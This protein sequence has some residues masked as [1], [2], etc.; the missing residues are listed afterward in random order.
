MH[1]VVQTLP[2]LRRLLLHGLAIASLGGTLATAQKPALV[3]NIDEPGRVP[4]EAEVEFIASGCTSGNC[5]NFNSLAASVALLD[6]NTPVPAGKRLILRHISGTL[7]DNAACGFCSVALQSSQVFSAEALK[8]SFL[9]PFFGGPVGS[10]V[11]NGFSAELFVTVGPGELPHL[12]IQ[13]SGLTNYISN[14][15]IS[16]YLIDAN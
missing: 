9:G 14:I 15:V 4:Y 6:V 13:T 16:G 12:R 8:W 11:A 1:K 10:A 7:F 5:V 3:K 2:A